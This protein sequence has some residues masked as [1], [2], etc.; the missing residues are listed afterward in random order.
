MSALAVDVVVERPGGFRLEA[1]FEV[2]RGITVMFGPSGAGKST[3]L[4]AITGLVRPA[5]GSVRLGDEI[6]FDA[7][8]GIDREIE[9]RKVACVFQSLAL[10]P[11]LTAIENVAYGIGGDREERRAKAAGWLERFRIAK[12]AERRPATF[13]GGEAQRVALA[14]ALAIEPK[15]VLLDEAFSALDPPLRKELAAEVRAFLIELDVPALVVTHDAA[16]AAALG[17]RGLRMER[18]RIV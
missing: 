15:V 11:H 17:A 10:F 16:E 6:W 5:S 18:G 14:R 2:P 12:I 9:A 3:A 4:G 7:A 13:S 8:R 1:A